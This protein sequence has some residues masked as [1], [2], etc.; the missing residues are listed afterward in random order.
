MRWDLTHYLP[1]N[2]PLPC[3]VCRTDEYMW[4]GVAAAQE[5]K[6]SSERQGLARMQAE[7]D[8]YEELKRKYG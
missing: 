3:P 2:K 6:E 1:A 8:R 5:Q 7:R 4:A